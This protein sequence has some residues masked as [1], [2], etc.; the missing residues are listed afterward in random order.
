MLVAISPL[1]AQDWFRQRTYNDQAAPVTMDVASRTRDLIEKAA[2]VS[3][4]PPTPQ[5]FAATGLPL[6]IPDAPNTTGV[7]STV[8]VPA[9]V[10]YTSVSVSFN[11][12][13]AVG[14]N[15]LVTLTSPTGV[16]TTLWNRAGGTNPAV[17]DR[18]V[19]VAAGASIQGN[20]V[21]KVV[22]QVA[23][24]TG[25][26]VS[27]SLKVTASAG[28]LIDLSISLE[29]D[30]AGDNNGNTQGVAGSAEQDKWER[31][32]QYFADAVFEMTDGAHKIRQVRIFKKGQNFGAADIRWGKKGHPHVP[33]NGGVG[34]A[35]GHVEMFELFQEGGAGGA[36]YDML[37]DEIG[38]GYT[39]AHEW[40][41]YFLGV[42]D[43]Y[44][45]ACGTTTVGVSPSI[46][47]SQW[48]AKNGD[49]NWLNFSIKRQ[50]GGSFQDTLLNCQHFAYGASAWEVLARAVS[51]DPTDA[52]SKG[53]QTLGPRIAYPELAI[54]AP[55][56][57][58]TPRIDLSLAGA[59]PRSALDIVWMQGGQTMEIVID[60]SGSMGVE[61]KL[62]N[63]LTAARLLV[64]QAILGQSRIGVTQ[65]DSTA[66]SVFPLTLVTTEAIRSQ[67]K[68]AIAAIPLA[69][70]TEIGGAATFALNKVL[71]ANIPAGENKIVFLLTDGQSNPTS[72]LAV[73]PAYVA[74]HIPLF[75]FGF[76]ADVDSALLS[77]MASGTGGRFFQSPTTLAEIV[78]A[79]QAANAVAS[80]SPSL[81]AGTLSPTASAPANVA[82]ALDA[83][84]NRLQVSVTYTGATLPAAAIQLAQPNGQ[85][86]AAISTTTAAGSTL[87]FF[88]V[89]QPVSGTWQLVA[90]SAAAG[91]NI[92][93]AMSGIQNGV[94]YDVNTGLRNSGPSVTKPGP[95]VIESRLTH[96]Q[97]VTG[98]TVT[99]ALTFGS[100]VISLALADNGV[101]PDLVAGDGVYTTVFTPTA[102]GSHSLLVQ[103]SNPNLLARETYFGANISP[104]P[105]GGQ[106][107]IPAD[108][109]LGENFSRSQTIQFS[110]DVP[111]PDVKPTVTTQPTSQT[112]QVGDSA[113]FSVMATGNPFPTYQWQ[114]KAATA[115]TFTNIAGATSSTLTIAGATLAMSN[116][117]FQ[118]V[119]SNRAGSV[120]SA[121]AT[122]TVTPAA[123]PR[124][125]YDGDRSSD[126]VVY[127]PQ[128]GTWYVRYSSSGYST[129]T[130]ASFQWGLPG[131][132][133]ISGDFDGDGKI[134]LTVF[135]PSNGT[136]YIRYSAQAYNIATYQSY[137]WGLPGDIPI[138]ADFDGDRKT[139]LTVFRPSTGTWYIRYSTLGYSMTSFGSFQWGLPGDVPLS[140]DFD[141]D[142]KT[143]LV[144]WRPV[145]GTWYARYSSQGYAMAT[146]EA[147]QWGLPGDLPIVADFDG[148]RKTELA[149]WRPSNGT[150]YVRYSAQA[151]GVADA[152][153]WGLPGDL[154]VAA[155]YDADGKA[156]LTVWRPSNGT[157]Y[158]R[159]SAQDYRMS[160]FGVYQWG[161]PGDTPTR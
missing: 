111:L 159:Y 44:N 27:W 116:D 64:D 105:A 12:T 41:H 56:G 154:P 25:S 113:T 139:D 95:V 155:D 82:V 90:N 55:S 93:Y 46:M 144:V 130:A 148:D 103:F 43:E 22:D 145:N 36:D 157:W 160:G 117:Q 33:S 73:I 48:N 75:T 115:T 142:G 126:I 50:S 4:L 2:T 104:I 96:R 15:L 86:V 5:V 146:A 34:V 149:V 70:G 151:Y 63:A 79:F 89:V 91:R 143:D 52:T 3:P 49:R 101:A 127:R 40:G 35:G 81:G 72:A 23:T 121:V 69:G 6:A 51:G 85:Q 147:A 109:V 65:F 141:G 112:A 28:A 153:Q 16:V 14:S 161:L 58:A 122:L 108:A 94:G 99:S 37:A 19:T 156:E 150:W 138:A 124:Q 57:T 120:T 62:A 7:S 13:H 66:Q 67:I 18:A 8:A 77:Q 20:W 59:S 78:A 102:N 38:S 110:I 39:M 26:L 11:I 118:C 136:W 10:N 132:I 54:V 107:V 74:A 128:T 97:P 152:F 30:P 71:A 129:T 53:F 32:V 134:E 100:T 158:I 17:I 60:H 140:A 84:V 29:A 1:S 61:N 83:A 131:D 87:L 42:Y 9:I 45:P 31:I 135:R 114:R 123:A 98:A 80:S 92:S 125:D 106:G 24:T 68:A 88:D 21:L 133:P 137:Q 119:V 76:G 47:N